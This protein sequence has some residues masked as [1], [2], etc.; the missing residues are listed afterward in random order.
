MVILFTSVG[1]AIGIIATLIV[2]CLVKYFR[3]R[4]AIN[5]PTA[6]YEKQKDEIE[7]ES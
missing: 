2:I 4:R 1:L 7:I 3:R 6:I 5:L